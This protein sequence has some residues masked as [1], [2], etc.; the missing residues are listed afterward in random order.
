M[1]AIT[2]VLVRGSPPLTGSVSDTVVERREE[3]HD[4]EIKLFIST[5]ADTADNGRISDRRK[6]STTTKPPRQSILQWYNIIR[7]TI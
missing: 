6:Q 4:G 7:Y 3:I 5:T 2:L 1:G